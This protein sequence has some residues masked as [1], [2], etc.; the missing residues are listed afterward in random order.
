LKEEKNIRP[1]PWRIS[2]E[3]VYRLPNEAFFLKGNEW[4][5]LTPTSRYNFEENNFLIHPS[6]DRM[7]YRLKGAALELTEKTELVSS[8]V[9][10]GTLQLLPGSELVLLMADHQTTGGY[11]RLGHVISA[12]LPKLAQLRPSDTIQFHVVDQETAETLLFSRDRELNV[13]RRSCLD[14]LKEMVCPR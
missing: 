1:L 14:H 11:P 10:F 8:A 9:C 3:S 12:H 6:S 2:P 7:G 4:D 5:K 13:A